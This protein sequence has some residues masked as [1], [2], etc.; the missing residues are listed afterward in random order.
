MASRPGAH[1]GLGTRHHWL[2]LTPPWL[3]PLE[4]RSLPGPLAEPPGGALHG[5][6]TFLTSPA[7]H[8]LPVFPLSQSPEDP[9]CPEPLR[10]LST[11]FFKEHLSTPV[12]ST[13]AHVPS[14]VESR[15]DPLFAGEAQHPTDHVAVVGAPAFVTHFPPAVEKP[16][17]NQSLSHWQGSPAPPNCWSKSHL[18]HL[19][20]MLYLGMGPQAE[21]FPVAPFT[22]PAT[23]R[24]L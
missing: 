14:P 18:L 21:G 3:W 8:S 6:T 4:N 15:V 16:D 12:R 10:G 11:P 7:S 13:S 24:E 2:P 22:R 5:P 23:L 9:G 20:V 19:Q 1:P 17:F